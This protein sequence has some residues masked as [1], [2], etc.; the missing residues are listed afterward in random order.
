MWS[1]T[2]SIYA[3]QMSQELQFIDIAKMCYITTAC[4]ITYKSHF[5]QL[6]LC[7]HTTATMS[8]FFFF[9]YLCILFQEFIQRSFKMSRL[10]QPVNTEVSFCNEILG[11]KKSHQSAAVKTIKTGLFQDMNWLKIIWLADQ[12]RGGLGNTTQRQPLHE[13][14]D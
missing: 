14:T 3:K 4:H 5:P 6:L 8:V 1:R 7:T 11:E 2:S 13:Y 9:I 12:T 10:K